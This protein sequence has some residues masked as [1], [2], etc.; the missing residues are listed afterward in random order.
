MVY[1]VDGGYLTTYSRYMILNI[2]FLDITNST[3]FYT[4]FAFLTQYITSLKEFDLY[5]FLFSP[6][7]FIYFFVSSCRF[8]QIQEMYCTLSLDRM[9]ITVAT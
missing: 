2:S 8:S 5:D 3:S 6:L 1:A 4:L 7:Q 9:N